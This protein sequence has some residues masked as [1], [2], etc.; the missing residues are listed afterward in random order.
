MDSFQEV[1][2]LYLIYIALKYSNLIGKSPHLEYF[3]IFTIVYNNAYLVPSHQK[4][5]YNYISII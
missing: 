5:N 1:Y 2:H 4:Y 3:L